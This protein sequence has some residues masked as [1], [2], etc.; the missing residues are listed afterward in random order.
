VSGQPVY[1]LVGDEFLVEGAIDRIRSEAATDPLSEAV[2]DAGASIADLL[3]ALDT[4]SLLG[5]RRLVV[6]RDAHDLKKDQVEG[7][8]AYLESPSPHS[9]LALTASGKSR[10]EAAVRRAGSVVSLEI[11][12]GRRLAGWIRERAR[13]AA[14]KMDDRA[15]WALI[16]AVGSELRDLDAAIEQLSTALGAGARVGAAQVRTV[17]PRLADERIFALTDSVGRRRLPDAM[18][19][20]RRLLEQGE[21]ALLILGALT[22]HVRRLLIARRFAEGGQGAVAEALGLPGWRADRMTDQARSFRE[23]ELIA[24]MNVLA[25]ADIDMK[26]DLPAEA[27]PVILERAVIQVISGAGA[28][29]QPRLTLA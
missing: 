8:L 10:I 2:F 3:N 17:F 12:R 23:E 13:G 24:A 22:G 4:P 20:L 18:G 11:P 1:L 27:V 25:Q 5:G 15:A 16:D 19:T 21:E 28:P 14:L 7:L 26:S 29:N 9:V 6:L